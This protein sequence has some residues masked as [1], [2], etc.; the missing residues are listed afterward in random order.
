MIVLNSK[1]PLPTVT[2]TFAGTQAD[3]VRALQQLRAGIEPDGGHTLRLRRVRLNCRY[4]DWVTAFGEVGVV[5]DHSGPRGCAAL[6]V[7]QYRCADGLVRCVARR[8]QRDCQEA[9]LTIKAL[10]VSSGDCPP[11]PAESH[12]CRT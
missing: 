1:P 7:W 3:F 4:R 11:S 12:V 6:Q 2:S 5:E 9:R 10:Y 8:Y